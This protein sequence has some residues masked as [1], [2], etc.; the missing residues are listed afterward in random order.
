MN[1]IS[2]PE[3]IRLDVLNTKEIERTLDEHKYEYQHYADGS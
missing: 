1:R 2:P 3:I